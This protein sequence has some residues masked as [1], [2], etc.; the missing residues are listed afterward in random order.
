ML[1]D[2]LPDV[3]DATA[4]GGSGDP[5]GG[6][7]AEQR[8]T[9]ATLYKLGFPRGAEDQ[10]HPVTIAVNGVVP[11]LR[12]L[13]P[14]YF[15]DFWTEPGYAG[16]GD[17]RAGEPDPARA[18]GRATAHR[19]GDRRERGDHRRDGPYQFLSV[20]GVARARPMR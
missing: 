2:A 9:L 6:L 11:G 15:D 12:D 1:G 4:P 3:V 16:T 19:G 14:G 10:I 13:D 5:F 8:V 7:T 18:H 20:V 17:E